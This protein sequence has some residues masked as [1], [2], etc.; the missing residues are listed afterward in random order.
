MTPPLV[1]ASSSPRR[2]QVLET[3]GFQFEVVAAAP[4]TEQPWRHGEDPVAFAERTAR[5]KRDEVAVTRPDALVMAA[6]TVVILDDVVLEKPV[7]ADGARAMLSKLAGRDHVVCTGVAV[8]GPAGVPVSGAE[9]TGVHFRDL[10]IEEIADYV[11]TGEPL[12]K[13]G[14]YG[15]QGLGAALVRRVD[16]CYFNV[17]GLPVTRLL[18]L[19]KE[20]GWEYRAPGLLR[21][22]GAPTR[23]H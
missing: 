2:K 3:I 4:G 15:I 7:D 22:V 1:L 17:M 14:A 10:D 20:V 13:A 23:S 6:D 21:L 11:A 18:D 8:V 16:G 5:A 9:K 19:L 12:D